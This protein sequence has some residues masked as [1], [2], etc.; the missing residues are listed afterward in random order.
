MDA[1]FGTHSQV[2]EVPGHR[3]R[4]QAI[5]SSDQHGRGFRYTQASQSVKSFD[6]IVNHC[7]CYQ[8]TILALSVQYSGGREIT[9]NGVLKLGIPIRNL[10][11]SPMLT[12]PRTS[13][14][15]ATNRCLVLRLV[16]RNMA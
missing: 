6:H 14:P 16:I 12:S 11:K 15:V 10:T 13:S 5:L 1:V 7:F 8:R 9:E 4:R 3:G 2:H